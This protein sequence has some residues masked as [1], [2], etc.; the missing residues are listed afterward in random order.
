MNASIAFGKMMTRCRAA[1]KEHDIKTYT[2]YDYPH[3]LFSCATH[4]LH[5][6]QRN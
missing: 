4:F 6:D 3:S 2:V 1:L 5:R